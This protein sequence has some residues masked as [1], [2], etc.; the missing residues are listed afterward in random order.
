MTVGAVLI[1]HC[2]VDLWGLDNNTR[3]RRQLR[4][5]GIVDVRLKDETPPA[6][7]RI[8]IIDQRFLFEVKTLRGLLVQCNVVL[9]A[10]SKGTIAAAH[11]D[12]DHFDAMLAS[13]NQTTATGSELE[14][15]ST[16][17]LHAYDDHLR[18]TEPPL[19]EAVSPARK[20]EL[21][22][23]L[24][25]N[26]Y[27]GITDFV[28]KWWW[29]KPA[30]HIVA[31]CAN[32]SISANAVTLAGVVLMFSAMMLFAHGWFISGLI[33]GWI[34]TLLDTVDGKLARVTVTSSR[35][36]HVMDHGM[37]IVHPPFWYVYWGLGLN[38]SGPLAGYDIFALNLAIVGGYIGGRLIEGAFHALGRCSMFAWRPFDAYFRLITARR[39]PCMVILSVATIAGRPDIGFMGIVLWTATSSLILLGRLGYAIIERFRHGP[40]HSWLEVPTAASDFPRAFAEF[41]GTKRAYR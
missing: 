2:S 18:R 17:S 40:L 38:L 6:T 37:D 35:I 7:D 20:G 4:A 5:I 10:D 30:R 25:G 33:C 12:H 27:K 8:L 29:P 21:E 1:G 39:N 34:M 3:L 14:F 26:S 32:H 22:A 13:F 16:Q 31:W 28:T 19:L 36:G 15:I 23:L 41:S 11:G 9:T 24:Y